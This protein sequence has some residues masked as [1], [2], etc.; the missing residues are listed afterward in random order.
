MNKKLIMLVIYAV[1]LF[2]F[3]LYSMMAFCLYPEESVQKDKTILTVT[4]TER[5]ENP[6]YIDAMYAIADEMGG[7]LMLCIM[8]GDFRNQYYRTENDPSFI[9]IEGLD[10][11]RR[12]ST[13]PKDGE[14]KI[15]GF[16]FL[17]DRD[18]QIAPLR[19]LEGTNVDFS[20]QKILIPS[21]K[22][23]AFTSAAQRH[24]LEAATRGLGVV[25]LTDYKAF[26]LAMAALG[27]FL[28]VSVVFY[29]FSRSKDMIV[30]K[31]MGF[32][33]WEIVAVELRENCRA[34]LWITGALLLSAF[35]LFSLVSDLPSTLF[36]LRVNA[37]MI[38]LYLLG[39]ALLV[40][41]FIFFVSTRCSFSSSKGKSFDRQLYAFTLAF[42][43]VIIMVIALF[44]SSL[45]L[46][47]VQF[48][49]MYRATKRSAALAEGYAA[50]TINSRLE[51]ADRN[52]GRYMP[53]YL[54]FYRIMHDDY[55]LIIAEFPEE[56]IY[57][58]W[59]EDPDT[60]YA[61][62]NDNYLDSFD[63]IY[64]TDGKPIRSDSLVKGKS[65]YL[66][67]EHYDPE[68]TVR[69]DTETAHYITYSDN[70]SFFTFSN[71]N[72][73]GVIRGARMLVEVYDPEFTFQT[74]DRYYAISVLGG[75]FSSNAYY[76]YD[77]ASPL[78]PYEQVFPVVKETGMDKI[79][80]TAPTV[81]QEFLENVGV[82]RS[83]VLTST[84]AVLFMLFS[85]VVII[86]NVAE[87]DYKI[88]ARDFAV[89]CVSG[90]ALGDVLMF[91]VLR[92][93]LIL[94]VLLLLP[95]VSL[96]VAI[97]CVLIELLIY[98]PCMKRRYKTNAV[99]VLKGE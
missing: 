90:Y 55:N 26:Y 43:A 20:V 83:F 44:L 57:H 1:N 58:T 28:L 62:I 46:N 56:Q 59:R 7:D 18:F 50:T 77:T 88:H 24:G 89:K 52:P 13:D 10:P 5:M 84:A 33:N 79:F 76:R 22:L 70:S 81:Q 72:Q 9:P 34:L 45:L 66:I 78:S 60:L 94:P 67:S 75:F 21:D 85:L 61:R 36:Y 54:S 17:R 73:D 91:R 12:Y 87:L 82:Y 25:I 68:G 8:T 96:A 32:T 3:L 30:K 11:S 6:A 80:L 64:G 2:M 63:T 37:L 39:A 48:Y 31:T 86:I 97:G 14:E 65:N 71:Y 47:A 38:A 41:L 16:F 19:D 99:R 98:I 51:D 35:T 29:A 15:R 93:L 23:D 27:F 69:Q 4:W 95:E 53:I 42:K 40:G 74:A 49:S 92:K